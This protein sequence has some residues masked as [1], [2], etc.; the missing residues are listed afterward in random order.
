MH[1]ALID[2]SPEQLSQRM[3]LVEK[4]LSA[5]DQMILTVSLSEIAA[6]LKQCG[7]I[8]D[9]R[10][11]AVPIETNMYQQARSAKLARDPQL[12]WE[13]FIEHGVFQ[14]LNPLVRGRRS[15]LLGHFN[16][17]GDEQG[18]AGHFA[19][20]RLTDDSIE[21]LDTSRRIQAAMGLKRPRGMSDEDWNR[22]LAEIQR[23]QAQSKQ[24]ASY[25]M[26]LAHQQQGNYDVA[27]NWL[28]I[29]TLEKS[30]EGPW[31]NGARYNLA[32]CHEALGQAQRAI[33]LYRIDES[34]QRHGN[35]LRAQYLSSLATEQASS[36]PDT[37]SS[38]D[39]AERTE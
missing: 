29:R 11:W 28:N 21:Q 36:P 20:A 17:R 13:E 16:K 37:A 26:G 14:Q 23:L 31:T 25:W 5:A 6:N 12:Q 22:R 33:Q 34:P 18:A 38:P 2:A 19:R 1:I 27:I 15:Y 7:G 9:V 8:T 10:L 39:P 32:R 4:R 24:H 35:L 30:P 3:V